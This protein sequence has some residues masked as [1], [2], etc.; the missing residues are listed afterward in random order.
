MIDRPDRHG[1]TDTVRAKSLY[2][3]K[4]RRLRRRRRTRLL[5][6]ARRCGLS[7]S[8]PRCHRPNHSSGR[9]PC[10]RMAAV[11]RERLSPL[12]G[13]K[14]SLVERSTITVSFHASLLVAEPSG[15][16]LNASEK[17]KSGS[18]R[19]G[20]SSYE[21]VPLDRIGVQA[22]DC[23]SESLEAPP[24]AIRPGAFG[25]EGAWRS[26]CRAEGALSGGPDFQCGQRPLPAGRKVAGP[27]TEPVRVTAG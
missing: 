16:P 14:S 27:G 22:L 23:G 10:A 15:R 24:L 2:G 5:P 26:S 25:Q 4:K 6:S 3:F 9:G 17:P 11:V 18:R 20:A 8:T 12:R 21:V 1:S 7:S 13:T 19:R